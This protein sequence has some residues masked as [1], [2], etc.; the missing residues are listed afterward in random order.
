MSDDA[1]Y[2]IVGA[3]VIGGIL[4]YAIVLIPFLLI[5]GSDLSELPSWF[6]WIA[7]SLGLLIGVIMAFW[8]TIFVYKIGMTVIWL[9][10]T[11][12]NMPKDDVGIGFFGILALLGL[13]W[14]WFPSLFVLIIKLFAS[15]LTAFIGG[16]FL[17]SLIQLDVRLWISLVGLAFLV[18][19]IIF[20]SISRKTES[21]I[22]SL[23]AL[24]AYLLGV[25]M[26]ITGVVTLFIH[27]S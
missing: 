2:V 27:S 19:G 25:I 18:I 13:S 21:P 7:V 15:L 11:L 8:F 17:F 9:I 6:N 24:E 14:I 22:W 16:G 1:W 20:A 5:W 10:I 12:G 4:G 3:I 26:I 23:N